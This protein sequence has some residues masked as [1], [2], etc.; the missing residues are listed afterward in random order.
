[1]TNYNL[2]NLNFT[3]VATNLSGYHLT[4]LI[5]FNNP[6]EISPKLKQDELIWHL[7]N[8]D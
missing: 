2:W 8:Y 5:D 3:W 1:M 6:L 4:I 7:L